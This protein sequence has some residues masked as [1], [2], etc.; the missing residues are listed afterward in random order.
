[1][2]RNSWAY[3]QIEKAISPNA[4]ARVCG[5]AFLPNALRNFVMSSTS[6]VVSPILYKNFY[7]QARDLADV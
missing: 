4:V 3:R 1:M 2:A 6:F 7:P 5:A